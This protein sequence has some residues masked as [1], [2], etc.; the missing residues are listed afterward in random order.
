MTREDTTKAT[1][2]WRILSVRKVDMYT[3]LDWVNV[4]KYGDLPPEY[5]NY[6][7]PKF[8]E[9]DGFLVLDGCAIED[10]PHCKGLRRGT[11]LEKKGYV[12]VM[13]H[14]KAA[15]GQLQAVNSAIEHDI[16]PLT[17]QV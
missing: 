10:T 1:F 8:W 17:V 5:T 4:K 11:V 12:I 9:A 13:A 2:K 3:L 14:L 6:F 15:A 16:F 7:G